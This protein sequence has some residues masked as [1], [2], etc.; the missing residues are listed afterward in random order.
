[1]AADLTPQ[2]LCLRP[3]PLHGIAEP[4][5]GWGMTDWLPVIHRWLARYHGFQALFPSPEDEPAAQ[6][7]A[8]LQA[9]PAQPGDRVLAQGLARLDFLFWRIARNDEASPRWNP[10]RETFCDYI[11]Q[12]PPIAWQW[13]SE[14]PQAVETEAWLLQELARS[15]HARE[16][17]P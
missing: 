15:R 13:D 17:R 4:L 11:D 3:E 14:Y 2:A 7:L 12:N 16:S 9:Q 10:L 8:F 5:Q 6:V 1:M